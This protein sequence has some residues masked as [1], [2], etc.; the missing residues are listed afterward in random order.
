M[1]KIKIRQCQGISINGEKKKFKIII[2]IH[3]LL[4][5]SGFTT[6]FLKHTKALKMLIVIN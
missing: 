2:A 3:H 6:F 1:Y 5:Y 4:F